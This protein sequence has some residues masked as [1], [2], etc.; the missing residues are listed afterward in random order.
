VNLFETGVISGLGA[1][2]AVAVLPRL[3]VGGGMP[4]GGFLVS[5]LAGGV[6]GWLYSVLVMTCLA[7]VQV[8]WNVRCRRPEAVTTEAALAFQGRVACP[9]VAGGML[10][11]AMLSLVSGW[12]AAL[13]CLA[14]VALGTAAV[15]VIRSP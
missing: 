3:G 6:A 4:G 10:A 2:A 13:A 14:V 9:G 12:P 15:A 1:G 5:L 7:L 8:A 11:A